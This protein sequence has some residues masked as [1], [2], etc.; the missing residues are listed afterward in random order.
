MESCVSALRRSPSRWR[1]GRPGVEPRR[2]AGDR[3]DQRAWL[4]GRER[5]VGHGSAGG[6]GAPAQRPAGADHRAD[7]HL[8]EPRGPGARGAA[9]A[10]QPSGTADEPARPQDPGRVRFTD[11]LIRLLLAA[12]YVIIFLN[13]SILAFQLLPI[14]GLD[15]WNIIETLFRSRNPRFFFDVSVRRREVWAGCFIVLI[16]F[17]FLGHVNLL[18]YVMAPFYEPASLISL[19]TCDGYQTGISA[20]FPCLV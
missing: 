13:L 5:P 8:R 14:P 2:R 16:A 15:G 19:H 18:W 17:Q 12:I 6:S 1:R 11:L 10:P 20:L 7:A 3:A 9:R 4:A